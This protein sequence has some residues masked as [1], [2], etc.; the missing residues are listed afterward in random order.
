MREIWIP[1]LLS[2]LFVLVFL[3]RPLFKGLWPLDGIAWFPVL[4][5][6]IALI[7]FPAYGFRPECIPLLLNHLAIVLMNLNPL[8]MG[9]SRNAGF[10]EQ[11]A[12]FTI[13]ALGLLVLVSAVALWFAPAPQDAVNSR[14]FTLRG[15]ERAG[16]PVYT[17]HVFDSR[18]SEDNPPSAADS[19]GVRPLIF[20]VPP[21]FGR[22]D[23]VDGIC[24]ALGER[25]VTVIS[26]TR[27][28]LV[29]PGRLFSLWRAFRDGTRLK[30]ANDAGRDLEAEKRAEIEFLL[31]YVTENLDSLAPAAAGAPLFL[32]GWGAGGSALAYLVS[33][34]G[35][36]GP[37][38]TFAGSGSAVPP[39]TLYGVRGL[40]VVEGRFWSSRAAAPPES[41]TAS[42]G[43]FAARLSKFRNWF[44]RFRPER[45]GGLEALPQP[46]VP[47]LY[48]VSSQ[49]PDEDGGAYAAVFA[50]L[51]N[52]GSSAA[53]ARVE[54]AGPLDYSDLPRE[55][56][57]YNA[58]LSGRPGGCAEDGVALIARFCEL[59]AAGTPKTGTSSAFTGRL[60]LP[61]GLYLETRYWNFE[62]IQLY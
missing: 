33:P 27:A 53:L 37:A 26:Y 50:A 34:S 23:A 7:I 13:P 20:L 41:A 43:A 16:S 39:S 2:S 42:S 25:G 10:H 3:V 52:S 9:V 38:G 47:A 18:D 4:A 61:G 22:L 59:V 48:L 11:G 32:A 55:Y 21:D 54:G 19:S 49:D 8:F 28:D 62:D 15:P 24:A 30:K 12:L 51:R 36:G 31:P 46:L 14:T 40:I 5:L 45:T 6:G 56:P 1:E 35:S 29:S 57:L 58:L 44:S 60:R 17:L